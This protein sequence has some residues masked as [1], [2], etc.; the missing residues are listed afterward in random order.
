ME[1]D[2]PLPSLVD[3][4]KYCILVDLLF[5]L[6]G[7]GEHAAVPGATRAAG[8]GGQDQPPASQTGSQAAQHQH[9]PGHN[10][11]GGPRQLQTVR[12]DFSD[13]RHQTFHKLWSS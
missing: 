8:G 5:W 12:T 4:K 3:C 2:K 9:Q 11:G 6:H 1:N 13:R 10:H 7:A